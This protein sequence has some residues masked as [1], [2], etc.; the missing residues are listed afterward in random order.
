LLRGGSESE[1]GFSAEKE[2]YVEVSEVV[3]DGVGDGGIEGG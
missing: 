3:V 2:F 1:E